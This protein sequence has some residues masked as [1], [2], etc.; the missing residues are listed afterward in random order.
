[1]IKRKCNSIEV[2]E[3]SG[4]KDRGSVALVLLHWWVRER[5][6]GER[7]SEGRVDGCGDERIKSGNVSR[8]KIGTKVKRGNIVIDERQ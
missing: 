3:G 4:S 5:E 1:M 7:K 8:R 2:D 6:R